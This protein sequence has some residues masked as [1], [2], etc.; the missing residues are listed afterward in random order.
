MGYAKSASGSAFTAASVVSLSIELGF[1]LSYKEQRTHAECQRISLAFT[2][3]AAS[4]PK[5]QHHY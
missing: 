5:A 4:L 1:R 2:E 3:S